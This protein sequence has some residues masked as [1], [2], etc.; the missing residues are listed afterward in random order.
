MNELAPFSCEPTFVR[1][2]GM[3]KNHTPNLQFPR[4]EVSKIGL[5]MN[6]AKWLTEAV[7]H[8]ISSKPIQANNRLLSFY[9]QVCSFMLQWT[10]FVLFYCIPKWKYF[11]WGPTRPVWIEG[12]VAGTAEMK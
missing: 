5:H 4:A 12:H 1:Y 9:Q 11:T 2:G 6:H 3:A 10:I 8:T 7:L